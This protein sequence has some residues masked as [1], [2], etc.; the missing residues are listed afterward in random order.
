MDRPKISNLFGIFCV[1]C[2]ILNIHSFSS[3][4]M[5]LNNMPKT[6]YSIP[7]FWLWIHSF[8]HSHLSGGENPRQNC[9]CEPGLIACWNKVT[10]V[11]QHCWIQHVGLVRTLCWGNVGQC[12]IGYLDIFNTTT[13]YCNIT[14]RLAMKPRQQTKAGE[15]QP[16]AWDKKTIGEHGPPLD[17]LAGYF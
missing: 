16:R 6:S 5:W 11:I 8:T 9:Q 1:E 2:R 4:K 12:W 7:Y 3:W 13:A 17:S 14:L 15:S 10:V